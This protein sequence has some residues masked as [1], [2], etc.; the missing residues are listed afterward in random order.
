M[1][2]KM[3]IERTM[4]KEILIGRETLSL[5]VQKKPREEIALPWTW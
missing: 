5:A 3:K 4:Q 2:K 1:Q